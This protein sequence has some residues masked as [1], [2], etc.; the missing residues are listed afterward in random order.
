MAGVTPEQAQFV[1]PGKAHSVGASYAHTV[2]GEDFLVSQF[3]A[4]QPP[5][6]F[7]EWAGR[8]GL[9]DMPPFG[10]W[11]DWATKVQVDL[12]TFRTYAQ[13]VYAN[14]E[15]MLASVTED[16]LARPLDLTALGLG[17]QTVGFL[18]GAVIGNVFAHCGEISAIKGV[19]GLKG[20]P[21]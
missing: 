7:G 18:L 12:P 6:C 1:P 21:F 20:Y 16:D 9:S 15:A 13:A 5:L 11:A 8:L 2:L 19:Q 4:G 3:V 10:D 14:S 17:N